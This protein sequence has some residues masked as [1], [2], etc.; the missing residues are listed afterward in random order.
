MT[1]DACFFFFFFFLFI[2]KLFLSNLTSLIFHISHHFNFFSLFNQ[3]K[4]DMVQKNKKKLGYHLEK[5]KIARA[6]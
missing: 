6:Y 5:K 2:L 4:K 3:H 1:S